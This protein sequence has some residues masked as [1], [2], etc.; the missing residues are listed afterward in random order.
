MREDEEVWLI[1]M[2]DLPVDTAENR[3]EATR[4]RK[5]LIDLGFSMAQYSVYCKYTP[6]L[7]QTRFFLAAVKSII[8]PYGGV[9]V[10]K[11]TERQY[12]TMIRY[13]NRF[14]A[15]V[16]GAPEQLSLFDDF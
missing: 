2:F 13:E 12:S 10:L 9:R 15:E 16:E 5:K 4:F 11:V 3:R 6:T 14:L 8:P 1:V 7:S